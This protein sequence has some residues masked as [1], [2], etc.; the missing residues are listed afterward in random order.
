[1]L[2]QGHHPDVQMLEFE[3]TLDGKM[4]MIDMAKM[5]FFL[6]ATLPIAISTHFGIT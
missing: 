2:A 3:A 1:M 5:A 4:D 6:V